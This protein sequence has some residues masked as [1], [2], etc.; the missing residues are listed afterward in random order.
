MII[1]LAGSFAFKTK[2]REYAKELREFAEVTSSWLDQTEED[3]SQIS[4]QREVKLRA[5]AQK[6]LND[7][8]KAN[9][10]V[11]ISQIPNVRGGAHTELGYAI[12][13]QKNILIVGPEHNVFHYMP[14]V[15]LVETWPEAV[16]FLRQQ[17]YQESSN[18]RIGRAIRLYAASFNIQR[19]FLTELETVL[20][21]GLK[22]TLQ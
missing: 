9:W 1:Y 17:R 5:Y 4:D 22:V 6:D 16:G 20:E 3:D 2:F 15:N 18:Q 11:Q 21:K 8:D 13:K 12:A 10:F 19:P 7:I 14:Q